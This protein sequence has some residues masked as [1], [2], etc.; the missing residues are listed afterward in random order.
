MKLMSQPKFSRLLL[1]ETYDFFRKWI[2][3]KVPPEI[4]LLTDVLI[5][6]LNVCLRLTSALVATLDLV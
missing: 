1:Q 4:N 2:K 5:C 6:V 3:F